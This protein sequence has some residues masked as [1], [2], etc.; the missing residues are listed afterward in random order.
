[1]GPSR[2]AGRAVTQLPLQVTLNDHAVFSSF[3]AGQNEELVS[4]LRSIALGR[5]GGTVL[6]MWGGSA[7]GKSHLLQA[8][9]AQ[10]HRCDVRP[11]YLPLGEFMAVG[12]H[13]L[14]GLEHCDI[15]CVD[16][17]QLAVGDGV[18]E[19]GIFGLYNRV[20]DTG[21]SLIIAADSSPAGTSFVLPDLRSRLTS[22]LVYHLQALAESDR[23]AALQLRAGQRGLVMPEE[24]AAFLMKRHPRDMRSLYG[25]LDSLDQAS[26]AAQRRLTIPFVKSVL[27]EVK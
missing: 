11:L 19:A 8:V 5:A 25:L 14:E 21:S 22:S 1:M 18:W 3:F 13:A 6:W 20:F 23:L 12:T 10:A 2:L 4:R 26:L 16:D 9:C 17:I 15:A 27:E 7:T 24:T